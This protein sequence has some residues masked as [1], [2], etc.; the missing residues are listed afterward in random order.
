MCDVKNTGSDSAKAFRAAYLSGLAKF[1]E[2]MR[3]AGDACWKNSD[4]FS[5]ALHAAVFHF[6]IKPE[7]IA[8]RTG[9]TTGTVSR[10]LKSGVR[11]QSVRETLYGFILEQCCAQF[12]DEE[13][14]HAEPCSL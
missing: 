2:A 7:Q 13:Q 4:T 14:E 6:S 9:S 1:V 11:S 10:W 3:Q 8:N 5:A 12:Q